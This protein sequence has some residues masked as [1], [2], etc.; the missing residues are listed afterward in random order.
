MRKVI[1]LRTLAIPVVCFFSQSLFVLAGTESSSWRVAEGKDGN[2]KISRISSIDLSDQLPLEVQARLSL[3][4]IESWV[5]DWVEFG[6]GWFVV[7]RSADGKIKL[8]RFGSESDY[9][10]SELVTRDVFTDGKRIAVV[11]AG[12]IGIGDE[13]R[14]VDR[15]E[16]GAFK[17]GDAIITNVWGIKSACFV[18]GTNKLALLLAI[19]PELK[20]LK[21]EGGKVEEL[22]VIRN[23]KFDNI[24]TIAAGLT[25]DLVVAG[26]D[27]V[28]SLKNLGGNKFSGELIPVKMIDER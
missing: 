11:S 20:V 7:I 23:L 21:L 3:V 14:F 8:W 5:I 26:P 12:K 6:D 18:P 28:F 13:I 2:E 17:V 19:L 22:Q 4:S 24:E 10:V 25:G 27:G 9:L 15:T 16:T 1:P